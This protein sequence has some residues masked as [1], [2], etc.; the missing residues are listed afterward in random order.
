MAIRCQFQ[1]QAVCAL[2][3]MFRD[4]KCFQS[5]NPNFHNEMAYTLNKT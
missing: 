1:S 4:L 3:H 5:R 2:I